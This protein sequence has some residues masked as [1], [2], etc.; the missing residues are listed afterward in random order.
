MNIKDR[1]FLSTGDFTTEELRALL[2]LAAKIKA[3]EYV[4]KPLAGKS[5]ALIFFN[6]S[7][8]TRASMEI[9]VYELG[10]NA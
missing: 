1:D 7:L 3:A 8:R 5:V 10:G 2:D 4:E 9:A 6:P